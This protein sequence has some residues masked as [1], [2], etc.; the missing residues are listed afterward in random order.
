MRMQRCRVSDDELRHDQ[1]QARATAQFEQ[2]APDM[3]ERVEDL[4]RDFIQ[5][6]PVAIQRYGRPY[7]RED[8]LCDVY[9]HDLHDRAVFAACAGDPD[10]MRDLVIRCAQRAAAVH[11]YGECTA[12]DLG[13]MP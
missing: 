11:L 7:T 13:F 12:D 6:L 8:L 3:R 5:G 2:E 4:A 1:A 10:P 9:E